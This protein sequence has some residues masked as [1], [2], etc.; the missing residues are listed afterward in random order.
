MSVRACL[1]ALAVAAAIA[2]PGAAAQETIKSLEDKTVEV[3]PG[4]VIRDSSEL[5]RQNYRD[6][7]DLASTDPE[8]Q[9]EALRRLGDLELEAHEAD[10]L[11]AN[12]ESLD[13]RGFNDA[14][15]AYLRLLEAYP[16]YRRNDTVLYQ[17]SRAYEAGGR[18][19]EALRASREASAL[20]LHVVGR[21]DSLI[22]DLEHGFRAGLERHD[23]LPRRRQSYGSVGYNPSWPTCLQKAD[24]QRCRTK[25]PCRPSITTPAAP[26]TPPAKAAPSGSGTPAATTSLSSRSDD[27]F[28]GCSS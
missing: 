25:N 17:L 6:F 14:A 8:L 9:A 27:R 21:T 5:A 20:D 16:N 23:A 24:Q 3:R 1:V 2:A 22:G 28:R 12:V 15:E 13:L 10:Q 11:A 7:L 19:E 18:P 26:P 4:K